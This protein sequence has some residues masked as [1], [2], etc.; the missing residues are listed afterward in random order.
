VLDRSDAP[1]A[2]PSLHAEMAAALYGSG[3]KLRAHVFGLGGR[4]LVPDE[5]RAIFAGEAPT[6]VALRS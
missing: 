1:G 5:A 2:V 4:E 6:H 3:A